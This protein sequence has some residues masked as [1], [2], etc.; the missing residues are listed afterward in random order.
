MLAEIFTQTLAQVLS[1]YIR[2]DGELKR[3]LAIYDSLGIQTV[4]QVRRML[5]AM[6]Y[7]F[8]LY[9]GANGTHANDLG[10]LLFMI[11]DFSASGP[12]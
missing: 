10:Q 2:D 4:A 8:R 5:H 7:A 11:A 9:I 6:P 1:R 12:E 3:R